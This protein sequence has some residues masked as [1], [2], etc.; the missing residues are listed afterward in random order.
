MKTEKNKTKETKKVREVK[1]IDASGR[2]LGRVA[3]EVA[4]SLM[5]KT[6]ATFERNVY[7]GFPV[8]VINAS[9][10]RITTKKLAE[11]YHTRYSG[12]PGGLRILK[13]T[14]TAEKKGLKELIKL[15][16]YQMLPGN[17]LRRIMMKNLTIED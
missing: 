15:A 7:S 12:I 4:M 3:S 8:K 14:E 9:K 13:G 17:K 1:I 16:T 6:K 5:G 10:L 11:I 2:T